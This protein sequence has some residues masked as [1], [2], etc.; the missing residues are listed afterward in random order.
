MTLAQILLLCDVE[1]PSPPSEPKREKTG[2]V[3]ELVAL[4]SM[5]YA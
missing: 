2:N 3:A 4:A 5:P 1:R